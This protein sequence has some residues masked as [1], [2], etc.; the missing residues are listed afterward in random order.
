VQRT[1]LFFPIILLTWVTVAV[2]GI[3]YAHEL[4]QDSDKEN[5]AVTSERP[6]SY[7]A[8][9]DAPSLVPHRSQHTPVITLKD[10]TLLGDPNAPVGIIEFIDMQ[11]GYCREFHMTTFTKIKQQYI[12]RGK[13]RYGIRHL[14]MKTHRQA[15]PAAIAVHCAAVN[16][17]AWQMVDALF[18]DQDHFNRKGFQKIAGNLGISQNKFSTCL[19]ARGSALKISQDVKLATVFGI[20]VTPSFAIG[21]LNKD[22]LRVLGVAR[23]TPSYDVFQKEIEKLIT[24]VDAP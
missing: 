7:R 6:S 9:G 22:K 15:L 1:R 12:D 19:D 5:P 17:K 16:G 10:E 24:N 18:L 4:G 3:C 8:Q 14:P 20:T 13:V 11:C 2:T 23:G 21:I